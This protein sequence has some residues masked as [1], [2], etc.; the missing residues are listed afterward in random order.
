MRVKNASATA[1]L[2]AASLTC[3]C[4]A[5]VAEG[6][7]PQETLA[8]ADAALCEAGVGTRLLRTAMHLAIFRRAL[9]AIEARTLPGIQWHYV[10]RKQR[11]HEWAVQARAQGYEQLLI[12]GAGF[13]G[14]GVTFARLATAS[15]VELDHPATQV[16]KRRAIERIDALPPN[17]R[18]H[19]LDFAA[20]R[21]RDTLR[22]IELRRDMPTLIVA[23]G[24]LMYLPQR[25]CLTMARE[26]M[27]WFRGRLRLAFS[28]MQLD[29]QGHVGFAH[30]SPAINRWLARRGEPFR[31]GCAAQALDA[32]LNRLQLR[33]L[34]RHDPSAAPSPPAPGWLPCPG[35]DLRLVEVERG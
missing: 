25:R 8:L 22:S 13:D 12:L 26:L 20:G 27:A 23:E 32:A 9:A 1:R 11:L 18:L 19:A 21:L 16:G 2:I 30:A 24:L 17:L 28:V 7:V 4:D 3:M 34:A 35:E 5:G 14:L 6:R 10:L 31:W 15:V 29:A 33:E